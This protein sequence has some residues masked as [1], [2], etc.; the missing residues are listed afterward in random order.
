MKMKKL[1]FLTL[2]L[3]CM[4]LHTIAADKKPAAPVKLSTLIKTANLAIKNKGGQAD[5]DKKLAEALNRE[6]ISTPDKALICYTRALLKES[7]NSAENTKAYLKQKYDT[8]VLF[9]TLLDMYEQL[10]LCD[11]LD[12]LPDAQGNVKV[13][14]A[15][16][17]RQLRDKHRPNMLNA[18]K[19]YLGKKDYKQAYRFMDDFY[20][21]RPSD[22]DTIL[23]HVTF[24]A[25]LC[26]YHSKMPNN[27]LKYVDLAI[28][29]APEKAQPIL[30]EF[31]VRSYEILKNDSARLAELRHGVRAYPQHD[32]FFLNLA[33]WY[34]THRMLSE[35]LAISDTLIS[36]NPKKS[37]Y[38][39]VKS[40]MELANNNYEKCIEYSDSTIR[41]DSSFVDA[42]YNKGLSYINLGI[43]AQEGACSDM[44]DPKCVSDRK[45]I[46]DLY[47]AAKPCMEKVRSMEPND[48]K[49]WA[50][51]LYRI[52]MTLNMGKEFDEIDKL[53]HSKSN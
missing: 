29:N 48:P 7:L 51:P 1:M 39:Y 27:T 40:K 19:F 46:Q 43:I 14:Y 8:T 9:N 11:S 31:K 28:Q 53:L 23:R 41:R 4:N 44:K 2:A 18:G 42:Y 38:W 13:K 10:R 49:R 37:I 21:Y 52:Y 50:S 12:V 34:F 33:D 36:F 20:T 24:W 3:L 22:K 35:G 6:D 15:S 16:K 17:S 45:K 5:A 32:Y 30:Q 25:A 26:G 47:H